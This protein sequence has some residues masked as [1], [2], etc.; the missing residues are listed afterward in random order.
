MSREGSLPQIGGGQASS[1]LSDVP[2]RHENPAQAS[3]TS[4][5]LATADLLGK[6][7][8]VYVTSLGTVRLAKADAAGKEAVGYVL[9][10]AIAGSRVNV[11]FLGK[12]GGLSGLTRGDRYYL[13]D[14]NAGKVTATPPT[15]SGAVV[16]YIGTAITTSDL[17]FEPEDGVIRA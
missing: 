10:T 2:R 14:T 3:L 17:M 13:S 5:N 1:R 8:L 16:Q 4:E 12:I 7:D 9:E 15:A 6:G 11:F